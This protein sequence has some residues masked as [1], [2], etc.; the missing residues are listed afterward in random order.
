MEAWNGFK[1]L[2]FGRVLV[3]QLAKILK[4]SYRDVRRAGVGPG[5]F[6]RTC[7]GK[8]PIFPLGVL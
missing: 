7:I 8:W 6:L 1:R 3:P 2:R 4:E 5:R